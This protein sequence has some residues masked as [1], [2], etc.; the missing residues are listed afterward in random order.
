[1][2]DSVAKNLEL[3]GRW[4]RSLITKDL[5]VIG[6]IICGGAWM[7]YEHLV[8]KMQCEVQHQ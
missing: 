1:S 3:K 5:L 2:K 4:N 7:L 8:A 6:G